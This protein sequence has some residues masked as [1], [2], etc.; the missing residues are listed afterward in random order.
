[1]LSRDLKFYLSQKLTGE[2]LKTIG[3]RFG[4]NDSAVSHEGKRAKKPHRPG[5]EIDEQ[6][7]KNRTET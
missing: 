4:I 5:P 6:N 3:D 2:T 1:M 7:P